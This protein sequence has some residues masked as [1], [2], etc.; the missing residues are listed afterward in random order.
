M[1][2]LQDL[3]AAFPDLATP[4][5]PTQ[6]VGAAPLEKFRTVTHLTP[7]LSLANAFTEEEIREF[8]ARL[9]RFLDHR[10]DDPL[11]RGTEAGRP[12]GEPPLRGRGA[13]R[14]PHPG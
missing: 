1:R 3:E 4:D 7:M 13:D 14:G 9:R 5:S 8:D 6:R 10:R 11:H 2:E 12:G